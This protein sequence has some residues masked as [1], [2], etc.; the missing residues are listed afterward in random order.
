MIQ[1]MM[2]YLHLGF[3]KMRGGQSSDE[4]FGCYV[5]SN[6]QSEFKFHTKTLTLGSDRPSL[7]AE[8]I[9]LHIQVLKTHLMGAEA[10]G[11]LYAWC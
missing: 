1:H 11:V 3:E 7:K 8:A 9:T 10:T 5:L 6:L 2:A 4:C